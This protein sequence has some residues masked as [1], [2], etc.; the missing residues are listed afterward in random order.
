MPV[1][2][3]ADVVEVLPLLRLRGDALSQQRDRQIR[4][5]RAARVAFAQEDRAEAIGDR[6]VRIER[7]R[8]IEQRIQQLVL[9]AAVARP[10][11]SPP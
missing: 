11:R 6:E 8:Q 1:V 2:D 10:S 7:G 5:A 3:E 9:A 4:T